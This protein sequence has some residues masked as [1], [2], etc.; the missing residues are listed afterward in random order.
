MSVMMKGFAL[1]KVIKNGR[2]QHEEGIA[3]EYDGDVARLVEMRDGK[4][5][6]TELTNDDIQ[7]LISIPAEDEGLESRLLS[8]LPDAHKRRRARG[9]RR[10]TRTRRRRRHRRRRRRHRTRPRRHHKKRRTP[11]KR[12]TRRRTPSTR[13]RSH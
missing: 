5:T 1:K 8:L 4:G 3:G 11:S 6:F 2:V 9:R 10:G 13:R 12:Q 7:K